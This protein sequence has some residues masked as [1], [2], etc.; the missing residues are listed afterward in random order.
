MAEPGWSEDD[1]ATY[2]GLAR[3]A[4][5]ERERQIRIIIELVRAADAPGDVL[6]L[7][8]G[9]GLL[10]EALLGAL[11]EA[12]VF[13]FDGSASML[14]DVA[15][16]LGATGRLVT[17]TIDLAARDWRRFDA[18]LR[19]VVSSLA[20]HHVDGAAKQ[21]LFADLFAALAPGG[22]FVLADMIL[23]ARPVGHAVAAWM[24]D[25][26]THRRSLDL[27]GD[28]RGFEVFQKAEWNNFHDGEPH[29]IDQPSTLADHVRWLEQAGFVHV[30]VHWMLA[31]QTVFSAWKP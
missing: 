11:P 7:C 17:R 23:P 27:H 22:V 3:Y 13:A 12:K 10:T 28:A 4:V 8:C 20:V 15:A 25:E 18:P 26:E 19:A 30:D 1:S 24:W 2:R 6:D 31:G 29:D 14:A 21:A 16:R 5:P 9:E